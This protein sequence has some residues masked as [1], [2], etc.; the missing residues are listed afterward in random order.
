MVGTSEQFE[1]GP[2]SSS[3][4]EDPDELVMFTSGRFQFGPDGGSET[5]D[6]EDFASWPDV[7]GTVAEEDEGTKPA[8]HAG[9]HGHHKR[10]KGPTGGARQVANDIVADIAADAAAANAT[11]VCEFCP[12]GLTAGEDFVMP[13]GDNATCGMAREFAE[14]VPRE[15]P[16]CVTIQLA[17]DVCCPAPGE[18]DATENDTTATT[19]AAPI[20]DDG[21]AVTE[22]PV[23]DDPI[24]EAPDI[25]ASPGANCT[26]CNGATVDT[27]INIPGMGLCQDVITSFAA[28]PSDDPKCDSFDLYEI[29]C[30]PVAAAEPCLICP[31][32]YALDAEV[33]A[34]GTGLT[35]G[36]ISEYSEEGT[37]RCD[38]VKAEEN[39]LEIVSAC[40]VPDA[41]TTE[42]DAPATET[43]ATDPA[44]ETDAPVDA[45]GTDS[46]D[47][48]AGKASKV[49]KA[50]KAKT[51]KNH[52]AKA[53][54]EHPDQQPPKSSKSSK[55]STKESKVGKESPTKSSAKMFAK[56][57]G[58]G[59]MSIVHKTSAKSSKMA[60]A[61]VH[62][63]HKGKVHKAD[64][65]SMKS[66][67]ESKGGKKFGSKS[68]AEMTDDVKGEGQMMSMMHGS[69]KS[70]KMAK[71]KVHKDHKGKVHKADE[72]S[73]KSQKE[74]KGGKKFGSKSSAEMTDDV[75]GEGQMMSMMHG[76]A[77]SAKMAKAKVHKDHK[78]K[79]HKADPSYSKMSAKSSK[80]MK[81]HKLDTLDTKAK[82][83]SPDV[84]YKSKQSKR[85]QHSL[86]PSTALPEA[87]P[88]TNAKEIP[89]GPNSTTAV[90]E[91]GQET[92]AT[93]I[94]PDSTT[95]LPEVSQE[96]NA[97]EIPPG[98]NSTEV[99]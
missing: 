52:M 50:S 62:K 82:K 46:E 90:P 79:A 99:P 3:D 71:A 32:G 94:P 7:G 68:S 67:K 93:E 92:N 33:E 12:D 86:Q 63:D 57:K 78:G 51:H 2:N 34:Q 69:A 88:E 77:K 43:D 39:D 5:E 98:T 18:D 42:P 10:D 70:A 95:A 14:S 11:T 83:I 27:T 29:L 47:G 13:T 30:C 21:T 20:V 96:T 4:T 72:M 35:C 49:A 97:T 74:S 37:E 85:T 15:N 84:S 45:P 25:E 75:K 1:F 41:A 89:P 26:I 16:A 73:M 22:A 65:M 31:E 76:S 28:F 19:T 64:E 87:S 55:S 60:K 54:K 61:K 8:K 80:S 66:Q 24:T 44:T 81:A 56:A 6:D 23:T 53:H 17:Q 40:C 58:K 36:Q 9:R 91:V 38:F 59:E 48:L